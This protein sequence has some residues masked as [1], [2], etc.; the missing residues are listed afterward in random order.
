MI[1]PNIHAIMLDALIAPEKEIH[2]Y[3]DHLFE[4]FLVLILI[5]VLLIILF[6]FLNKKK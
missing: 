2:R 6:I 5:I 3:Y 1:N 4:Y